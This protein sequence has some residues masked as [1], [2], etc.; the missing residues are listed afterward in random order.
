MK[1][2]LYDGIESLSLGSCRSMLRTIYELHSSGVDT[3]D[4]FEELLDKAVK[5]AIREADDMF[6]I[7]DA[8]YREAANDVFGSDGDLEFDDNATVSTGEDP[9]A[10]V[11]AWTWNA[12][13]SDREGG[14]S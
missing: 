14:A 1:P 9:G 11:A 5:E 8:Q 2:D 3:L 10:Y 13:L 12:K 7:T 6:S 4:I